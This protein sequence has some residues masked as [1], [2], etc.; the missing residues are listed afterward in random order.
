MSKEFTARLPPD[1][2]VTALKAP[3]K[4]AKKTSKA[5]VAF[6][7]EEADEVDA[8]GGSID[9]DYFDSASHPAKRAKLNVEPSINE[10]LV[11]GPAPEGDEEDDAA[12]DTTP[13]SDESASP[14]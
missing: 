4:R 10:A 9:E 12:E 6:E 14:I 13:A 7:N 8:K 11:L 1:S 5:V 3:R 2:V